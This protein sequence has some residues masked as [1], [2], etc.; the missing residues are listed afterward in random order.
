MSNVV[1]P[2]DTSVVANDAAFA[3]DTAV[4]NAVT[5]AATWT[6]VHRLLLAS[7]VGGDCHSAGSR[8]GA[9]ANTDRA[10]AYT[11]AFAF[12]SRILAP[13]TATR[14]VIMPTTRTANMP[15][16]GATRL[17]SWLTAGAMNN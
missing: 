14:G 2:T 4:D 15:W 9:F 12:R 10:A 16:P 6:E 8:N 5:A 11:A 7:C 1:T 17:E 3:D 13:T